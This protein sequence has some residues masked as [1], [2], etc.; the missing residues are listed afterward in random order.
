VGYFGGFKQLKVFAVAFFRRAFLWGK[1]E[2]K[3]G[4]TDRK[5]SETRLPDGRPKTGLTRL[6]DSAI[7]Y[8]CLSPKKSSPKKATANT[9]SCLNPPSN[10][11][12]TELSPRLYAGVQQC[13]EGGMGSQDKIRDDISNHPLSSNCHLQLRIIRQYIGPMNETPQQQQETR[14]LADDIAFGAQSKPAPVSLPTF[15]RSL[16]QP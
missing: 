14:S 5:H 16:Y 2:R 1:T 4:R 13:R 9:L 10:P 8:A 7:G 12:T 15:S 3:A 6:D 11:Q